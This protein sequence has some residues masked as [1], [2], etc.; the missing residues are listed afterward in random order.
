MKAG[1][2]AI[3]CA[4]VLVSLPAAAH[5][6]DAVMAGILRCAVVAG[7]R[8]W[9]DCYYGAAQPMRAALALAPALPQQVQLAAFPPV[10]GTPRDLA[11]RDAVMGEASRCQSRGDERAWLDCYY[12]A[13]QPMRALLGLAPASQ[14]SATA[15]ATA[16][17][18]APLDVPPSGSWLLGSS[19]KEMVARM[20]TYSFDAGGHFIAT[21]DNGEVWRQMPGDVKKARWIRPAQTYVAV[22]SHGALGSTNFA[23]QGMPGVFKVEQ[24]R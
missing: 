10:G 24:A 9:L 23:V 1:T 18:R 15:K 20:V 8:A 22:I 7:S 11:V 4:L 17:M 6:R 5:P 12:A 16:A 3:V 2:A 19:R 21:L 14:A 13:A